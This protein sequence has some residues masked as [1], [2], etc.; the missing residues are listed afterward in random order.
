MIFRVKFSSCGQWTGFFVSYLVVMNYNRMY[1]QGFD[2][3]TGVLQLKMQ[4]ACTGCPSSSVTLKAGVQN[5]MQFYI[6][7]VKRVE[8]VYSPSSTPIVSTHFYVHDLL[9][10]VLY[11]KL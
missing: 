4:G 10:D 7:E 1:L 5:M 2:A 3:E 9:V 8:Q 6:P 11:F